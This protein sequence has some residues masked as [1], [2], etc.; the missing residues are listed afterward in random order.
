MD[1]EWWTIKR[2]WNLFTLIMMTQENCTLLVKRFGACIKERLSATFLQIIAWHLRWCTNIN[3]LM[4]KKAVISVN[5]TVCDCVPT[6]NKPR[7]EH[8]WSICAPSLI[9]MTHNILILIGS[10]FF[11]TFD[12]DDNRQ[13]M[14]NITGPSNPS[15]YFI[16]RNLPFNLIW[17]CIRTCIC[18]A[19]TATEKS[20]FPK[21]K[22]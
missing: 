9:M 21:K 3:R 20:K 11:N 16:L 5:A 8:Q 4:R 10:H 2:S 13:I 15:P 18:I 1:H 17:I 14:C 6:I 22:T 19:Q 7:Q 12:L